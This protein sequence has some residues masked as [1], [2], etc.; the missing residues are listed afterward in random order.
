MDN[1]QQLTIGGLDLLLDGGETLQHALTLPGM[2]V[3]RSTHVPAAPVFIHLDDLIALP[4]CRWLHHYALA[5]WQEEARFGIDSEGIYYH[6]L[7]GDAVLRYDSRHPDEVYCSSIAH[8]DILRFALW[9]AYCMAG[10]RR[11][12]VP[13]HAS[14]IVCQKRAVLCLGESGTG[15][16]THTSLWC[17][18]IEGA[19]LLNDDSPILS[20]ADGTICVYG[21]PWSGKTPCYKQERHP[22]A[23][24]QR[25]EQAPHN[26]IHRLSALEA[27]AALQPS[28][29]PSLAHD[30]RCMDLLVNFISEVIK[31]TPV[32]RLQCLPDKAAALLSH[33]TIFAQP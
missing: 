20:I 3:F 8:P 18:H 6:T 27:F 11:G 16:S 25:I 31:Q 17:K 5:D 30:E 9:T 24:L 23:A 13:V 22:V 28:C 14:T 33:G 21:S 32:Y 29:P 1:P 26:T 15:K 19:Y 2:D 7:G 10:L 12:I 4:S